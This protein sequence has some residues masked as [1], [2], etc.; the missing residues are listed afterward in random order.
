MTTKIY[1]KTGDKGFTNLYDMRKVKKDDQIFEVLGDLDELS[2]HIGLLSVQIPDITDIL[3]LKKIQGHLLNI[4][5]NIATQ[6]NRKNIIPT[7]EGDT[8][9]LEAKID[10]YTSKC[11]KL[12]EFIIAGN[13]KAEACAHVCRAVC[14]RCERHLWRVKDDIPQVEDETYKYLNRLS[15]FLFALARYLSIEKEITRSENVLNTS[16]FNYL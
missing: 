9:Q 3:H 13:N 1:T 4:G 16:E 10:F 8:L 14:R 11:P 5:S 6:R 7:Q 15:D 12:T 2:A